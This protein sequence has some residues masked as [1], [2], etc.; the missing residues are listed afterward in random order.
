M[1]Q[2]QR[3]AIRVLEF[4]QDPARNLPAAIGKRDAVKLIL[5]RRG[6]LRCRLNSWPLRSTRLCR[7]GSN[8]AGAT[9]G[10][11]RRSG[12]CSRLGAGLSSRLG[13][14]V[15]SSAGVRRHSLRIRL[16]AKILKAKENSDQDEHHHEQRAVVAAAL[17]IGVLKLCQKGL[18]ILYC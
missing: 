14:R 5:N 7:R 3:L 15:L 4:F 10:R 6:G 16:R 1:N 8:R 9:A 11:S 17:L 2:V 18:P 13:T 12:L